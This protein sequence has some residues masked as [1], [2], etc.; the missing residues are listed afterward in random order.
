MDSAIQLRP[1]LRREAVGGV[2]RGEP[3]AES[4]ECCGVVGHPD[5]EHVLMLPVTA[6]FRWQVILWCGARR[7]E[8]TW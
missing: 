2:D 7:A 6:E 4:E 5:C 3:D 1:E 8:R